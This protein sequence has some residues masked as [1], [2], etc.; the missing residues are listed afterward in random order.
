[1]VIVA[2]LVEAVDLLDQADT[3]ITAGPKRSEVRWRHDRHL[4]RTFLDVIDGRYA[5][6]VDDVAAMLSF[7]N[8]A[9]SVLVHCH[10][11]ESRSV[12]VGIGLL[13]QA[14]VTPSHAVRQLIK[15]HPAGRAFTPNPL[16]LHH[17]E[18]VLAKPS[19]VTEV[20]A[21]V[22]SAGAML[23]TVTSRRW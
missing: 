22:P 7:G 14:G 9:G 1:M 15:Q 16:V 2:S 5:P 3:V 19:L 6:T 20:A 23:P 17:V 11:G 12:A 13:V 10:R 4:I 8:G 21:I 18:A